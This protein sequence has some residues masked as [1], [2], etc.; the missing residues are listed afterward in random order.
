MGIGLVLGWTA[1]VFA[2]AQTDL[3]E[4]KKKIS[5]YEAQVSRLQSQAKT[6]QS[7]I[8]YFD[9]QISLTGLQINQTE[10]EIGELEARI[11]SLEVALSRL[12]V[13][14]STRAAESYKM[15]RMQEPWLVLLTAQDLPDFVSRYHYLRLIQEQ[16]KQ[17]LL[18]WQQTQKLYEEQRSE[19]AILKDKLSQQ[20]QVLGQQKVNKQYLL[21]TTKNDEKKYQ[22]LLAQARSEFEAIQAILAGKGEENEVGKVKQGDRVASIISGE[23]CNSSGEHLHLIVR[24]GGEVQNPFNYFKGISFENCSGSGCGSSDGDSFNP[25]GSWDWPIAGPVEFTQGYGSTWAI[26]N[27]WV[28]KVYQFHNGIDVDSPNSEIKSVANGTLYRG[29][30]TGSSGCRLRYVRVAHEGSDLETMFLHV[31]Y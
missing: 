31:N 26:K 24:K 15:Q 23:S 25:S 2:Q 14:F 8:F 12:S 27:T 7:Q 6:L 20:R 13:L 22:S 9:K 16:D 29:S 30:F 5:E 28:G 19:I 1:N 10:K 4:I 17:L 21:E 3:E 18:S 11:G